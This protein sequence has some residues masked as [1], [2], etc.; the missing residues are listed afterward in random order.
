MMT[1]ITVMQLLLTHYQQQ[2]QKGDRP[3]IVVFK[4]ISAR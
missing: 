3:L 1:V 2:Y 4:G